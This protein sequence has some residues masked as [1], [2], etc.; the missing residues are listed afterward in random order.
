MEGAGSDALPVMHVPNVSPPT[1]GTRPAGTV[2]RRH[3]GLMHSDAVGHVMH[4]CA[5]YLALHVL[6]VLLT[7]ITHSSPFETPIPVHI[8]SLAP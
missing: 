7:P 1:R 8:D 2:D 5:L 6:H 4:T 3:V